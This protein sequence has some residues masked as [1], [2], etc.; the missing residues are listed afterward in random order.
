[1]C[2]FFG[3]SGHRVRVQ[4]V[5][6]E[7]RDSL[8]DSNSSFSQ[9]LIQHPNPPS[10]S[11]LRTGLVTPLP[12]ALLLQPRA[13][14]EAGATL[15]WIPEVAK[16]RAGTGLGCPGRSPVDLPVSLGHRGVQ[17]AWGQMVVQRTGQQGS[18]VWGQQGTAQTLETVLHS[19]PPEVILCVILRSH[20]TL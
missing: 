5:P 15:H 19:R 2:Y 1:M 9:F 16:G 11:A 6:A 14:Q 18:L 13:T 8:A 7:Q 12:R 10:D 4:W 3:K 20:R 17:P